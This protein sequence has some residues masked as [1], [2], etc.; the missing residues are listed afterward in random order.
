M[1]KEYNDDVILAGLDA[2]V[3][4]ATADEWFAVPNLTNVGDIGEQAE[5]KEKTNL[6][7]DIKKYSDGMQDAPDKSLEGQ[8]IPLQAATSPYF[9]EYTLQ[10]RFF[11]LCQERKEFMLRIKW[12]SGKINAFLFKSLGYFVSSPN[13]AE[14]KMFNVPGVQNTRM[15]WEVELSGTNTVA[16]GNTVELATATVPSDLEMTSYTV[17][18]TVW[19]SSDELIATVDSSGVVTGVAEGTVTIMAEIRGVIG[20]LEVTVTA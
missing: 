3:Y 16:I 6:S 9:T 4:D 11:K 2:E 8:I 18:T 5:K 15:L 14:W 20:Y 10:Q 7:D 12:K 17:D 19:S 1:L 13:Q